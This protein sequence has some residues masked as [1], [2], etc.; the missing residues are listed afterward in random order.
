MPAL[1]TQEQI[2]LNAAAE[3]R[4]AAGSLSACAAGSNRTGPTPSH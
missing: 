1:P 2:F 4:A 3:A